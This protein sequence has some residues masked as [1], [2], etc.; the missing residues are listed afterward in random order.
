MPGPSCGARIAVGVPTSAR[1]TRVLKPSVSE[2]YIE[3]V[4]AL[5]NST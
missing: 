2:R 4:P 3:R 1:R 5:P